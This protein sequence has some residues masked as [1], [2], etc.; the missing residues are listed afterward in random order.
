MSCAC[1][2][3][4]TEQ[5]A[6]VPSV[7][8]RQRLRRLRRVRVLWPRVDLQ[9]VDLCAREPVAGEH[10]LYGLAQ[11]LRR[12]PLELLAQGPRLQAARVAGVAV[13]HLLVELVARHGDPLRVD[14]DDEVTGVDVRRVL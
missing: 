4:G 11:H 10:P 3:P 12:T 7:L 9:L 13:V 5:S 6:S 8:Q 14:D 2:F 1:P